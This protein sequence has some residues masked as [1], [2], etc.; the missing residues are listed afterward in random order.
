VGR[1]DQPSAPSQPAPSA[2]SNPYFPTAAAYAIPDTAMLQ[3][4]DLPRRL[5]VTSELR[6]EPAIP[7]VMDAQACG[8]ASAAEPLPV[9]GR[10]REYKQQD[11]DTLQQITGTYTVT[12]WAK[13]TGAARFAGVVADRGTCRWLRGTPRPVSTSG[14]VGDDLWVATSVDYEPGS[15]RTVPVGLAVVRVG[16]QLVGLRVTDP[17]GARA[18]ADLAERL[19]TTAAARVRAAGLP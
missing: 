11:R 18:V 1:A 17:A 16:D 8:A 9:A 4:G 19:A 14:T 6:D 13:G 10:S 15:E 3:D 5:K 12:G 2:T 7:A